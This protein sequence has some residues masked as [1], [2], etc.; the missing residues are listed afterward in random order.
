MKRPDLPVL[1][2]DLNVAI[3]SSS[4]HRRG[5]APPIQVGTPPPSPHNV[6]GNQDLA[7]I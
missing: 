7:E 1:Q 3:P 4:Q 5:S 6:D 2:E